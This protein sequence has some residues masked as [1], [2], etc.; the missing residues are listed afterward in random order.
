MSESGSRTPAVLVRLAQC[1]AVFLAI[2]AADQVAVWAYQEYATRVYGIVPPSSADAAVVLF[3]A[4][5]GDG[6]LDAETRRRLEHGA[7]LLRR[8]TVRSL[9]CSG[10]AHKNR[11]PEGAETMAAYL[12]ARGILPEEI[13]VENRSFDTSTNVEQSTAIAQRK[14]WTSLVY[15]SSSVHL[16]RVR[17]F[18]RNT[19]IR[20]MFSGHTGSRNGLLAGWGEVTRQVHHEWAA[21]IG[22]ALL[23]R[24]CYQAWLAAWRS[25]APVSSLGR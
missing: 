14:G 11:L 3:S 12:T 17:Y 24:A 9:L 22:Y 20:V 23:P 6:S 8:G 7:G 2:L 1:T 25:G 5:D 15:V 18:A 16:P 10:G 19:G 13:L 4:F 21:W